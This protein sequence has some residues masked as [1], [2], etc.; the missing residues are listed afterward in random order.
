MA[1][2]APNAG[3]R[4]LNQKKGSLPKIEVSIQALLSCCV[5]NFTLLP[6][7][8]GVGEAGCI[9]CQRRQSRTTCL[10]HR[11]PKGDKDCSSRCDCVCDHEK[12]D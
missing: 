7:K 9:L 4:T 1:D 5:G 11:S 3:R 2:I 12:N 8:V 6:R 10:E